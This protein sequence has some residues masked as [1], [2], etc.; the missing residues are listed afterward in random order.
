MEEFSLM[1]VS[2]KK[3]ITGIF[4]SHHLQYFYFSDLSECLEIWKPGQ[5]SESVLL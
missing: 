4:K 2:E 5:T 1:L 3:K